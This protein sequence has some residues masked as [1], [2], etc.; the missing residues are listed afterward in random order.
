MADPQRLRRGGGIN[1]GGEGRGRAGGGEGEVYEQEN[2]EREGED[3][4]RREVAMGVRELDLIGEGVVGSKLVVEGG[5]DVGDEKEAGA[6]VDS[7]LEDAFT[8]KLRTHAASA[9]QASTL[10]VI[11]LTIPDS[12]NP[13]LILSSHDAEQGVSPETCYSNTLD[14]QRRQRVRFDEALRMHSYGGSQYVGRVV[15]RDV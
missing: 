15:D 10:P 6:A 5:G 14:Q 3:E 7:V 8:H 12:D 13:S 1:R 2:E 11:C 4:G 9:P